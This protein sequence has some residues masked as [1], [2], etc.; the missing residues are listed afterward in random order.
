MKSFRVLASA[1]A[2]FVALA[3]AGP[4]L[5]A[6][7]D[8]AGAEGLVAKMGYLQRYL[9]KLDLSV[10]AENPELAGYYIHE[11]EELVAELAEDRVVYEGHEVGAL[12]ESMLT[13]AIEA[14]ES[15]LET[16]GKADAA[17]GGL[18]AQCNACHV[19]TERSWMKVER[20]RSNPFNQDFSP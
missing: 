5:L 9:H 8:D 4:A 1:V 14:L 11:L 16:G 7:S 13:P 10:Q 19:A 6:E 20:A 17:V 12:T 3:P 2:C 18:V 15:A